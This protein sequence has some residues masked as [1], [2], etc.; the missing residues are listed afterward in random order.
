[1]CDTAINII[2]HLIDGDIQSG[3]GGVGAG[4]YGTYVGEVG[5]PG[6]HIVKS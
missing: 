3:W 1:M 2:G 5:C 4:H 6:K